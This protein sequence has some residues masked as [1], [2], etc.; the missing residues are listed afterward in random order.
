MPKPGIFSGWPSG[1]SLFASSST[2]ITSWLMQGKEPLFP[3]DLLLCTHI[4]Q[5]IFPYF[6]IFVIFYFSIYI[7]I[8]YCISLFILY[9]N[10]HYRVSCSLYVLMPYIMLTISHNIPTKIS[11]VEGYF[12][13]NHA[14]THNKPTW[15][16]HMT[17]WS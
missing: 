11:I 13:E 6:M 15:L 8:P 4:W 12:R 16:N 9:Y 1:L 17:F 10:T 14:L 5:V 7:Y 3:Y 2:L